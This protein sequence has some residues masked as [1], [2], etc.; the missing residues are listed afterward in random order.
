MAMQSIQFIGI[1][2]AAGRKAG[3]MMVLDENQNIQAQGRGDLTSVLAYAAGVG[4]AMI[5]VNAP[6]QLSQGGQ[7]R[8]VEKALLDQG[9]WIYQ[10]PASMDACPNSL[11]RGLELHRRLANL[12]YIGFPAGDAQRQMLEA[13]A[14]AAYWSLLEVRPFEAHTLEG[15]LQR[16]LALADCG[17]KV[18][19]AM[20][21]FEEI[22][23]H[24]LLH[25]MLPLDNIFTADELTALICAHVAWRAAHQP[26]NL[27]WLGEPG[28]GQ[29]APPLPVQQLRNC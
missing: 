16:Q 9:A 21:F 3:A 14:E 12:G 23:R 20:D 24:R 19:D 22:T 26:E 27:R 1:E 29:I 8:A 6:A 17:V 2:L 11:R 5:A 7:A 10:T 28:E 4:S 13:P 15:R 25:G 18:P